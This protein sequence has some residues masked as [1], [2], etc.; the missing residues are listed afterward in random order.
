MHETKRKERM[1]LLFANSNIHY[2]MHRNLAAAVIF[3][4]VLHPPVLQ[5]EG[6]NKTKLNQNKQLKQSKSLA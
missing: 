2:C 6:G 1:F 3:N 4:F 5:L